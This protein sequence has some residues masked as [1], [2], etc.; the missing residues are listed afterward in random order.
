MTS[1]LSPEERRARDRRE[2]LAWMDFLDRMERDDA[3]YGFYYPGD[4]RPHIPWWRRVLK[5]KPPHIEDSLARERR[6][7]E[8]EEAEAS[9]AR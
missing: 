7:L 9:R 3:D 2:Y 1:M 4:P 5:L 8:R 6:R